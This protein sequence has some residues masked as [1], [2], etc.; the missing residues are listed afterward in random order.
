MI[1]FDIKFILFSTRKKNDQYVKNF[2]SVKYMNKWNNRKKNHVINWIH[3]KI[4]LIA[5]FS[6]WNN[7]NNLIFN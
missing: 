2:Q 5:V 6:I 3:W 1:F 7:E 4:K